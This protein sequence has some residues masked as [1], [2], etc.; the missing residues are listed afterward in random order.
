ME[1][2]VEE[3]CEEGWN[4]EDM[5][6]KPMTFEDLEATTIVGVFKPDSSNGKVHEHWKYLGSFNMEY[7]ELMFKKT[8]GVD[9]RVHIFVK[10]GTLCPAIIN[11]YYTLFYLAPVLSEFD[12]RIAPNNLG[13]KSYGIKEDTAGQLLRFRR[14]A[15]PVLQLPQDNR[16]MPVVRANHYRKVWS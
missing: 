11:D 1:E 12:G 3:D 16:L 7:L 4:Y 8:S 5:V 15:K 2:K 10:N 6:N 9:N 14:L 13:D